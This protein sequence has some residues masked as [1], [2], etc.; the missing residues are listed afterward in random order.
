MAGAIREEGRSTAKPGP[1][2]SR[3]SVSTVQPQSQILTDFQPELLVKQS[4]V[5]AV[6]P[7]DTV[8]NQMNVLG[9]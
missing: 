3:T 1:T 6:P 7:L 5:L 8:R 2:P 9:A 4:C